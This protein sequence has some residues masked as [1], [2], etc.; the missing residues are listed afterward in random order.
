MNS[1]LARIL[2]YAGTLP[3]VLGTIAK[4][5]N[6]LPMIY[7]IDMRRLVLSYGVLIVSFMA[8]VHWGQ[9]LSGARGKVNLL[10]ASNVATLVAWVAGLLLLPAHICYVLIVLFALLYAID[11]GLSLAPAYLQTRRNV[12]LIVC[13]S[14]LAL[15]F[16]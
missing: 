15:S 9:Y 6:T 2:P 11:L 16:A 8:G 1:T 10:I 3:F 7:F 4:L 13:L 14:L 5:T 12:T